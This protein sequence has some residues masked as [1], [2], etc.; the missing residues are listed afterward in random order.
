MKK[1]N[2]QIYVF[3]KIVEDIESSGELQTVIY[4]RAMSMSQAS[5]DFNGEMDV[6]FTVLIQQ[7][8]ESEA[9]ACIYG[10]ENE[11]DAKTVEDGRSYLVESRFGDDGY[12]RRFGSMVVYGNLEVIDE[13]DYSEYSYPEVCEPVYESEP[14]FDTVQGIVATVE[15]KGNYGAT[16]YSESL[17]EAVKEIHKFCEERNFKIYYTRVW[18]ADN[19][20]VWRDVGSHSEFFIITDIE[21]VEEESDNAN[22]Q[23]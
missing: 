6:V 9:W 19:G 12:C 1:A 20:E 2:K 8:G 11:D 13:L 3:K 15:S 4:D 7:L 5:K 22:T 14:S 17:L 21:C 10:L 16:Y 23:M 18:K